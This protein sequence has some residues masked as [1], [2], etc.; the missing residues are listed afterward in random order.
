[1]QT[2]TQEMN[3]YNACAIAEGWEGEH[4]LTLHMQAWSYLINTGIAW[5]LQGWYGRN[6]LMLIEQGLI[7]ES[8]N[9]NWDVINEL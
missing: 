8:G 3:L 4:S 1:M 9:I 2:Q 7:D 6:A 5:E